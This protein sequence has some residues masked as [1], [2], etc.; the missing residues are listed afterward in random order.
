[1]KDSITHIY[2]CEDCRCQLADIKQKQTFGPFDIKTCDKCT[3]KR[4]GRHHEYSRLY[5]LELSQSSIPCS[6]LDNPGYVYF[7]TPN[8]VSG[9][10]KIG[11]T[12]NPQNRSKDI[13][14]PFLFV[15]PSK[16]HHFLERWM[17][18]KLSGFRTVGEWFNLK[19]ASFMFWLW[20]ESMDCN[21]FEEV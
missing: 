11:R 13:G 10:F 17:H 2:F 5:T 19:D 3:N 12:K 20:I 18:S 1:M 16:D 14:L 9:Q 15:I 4:G 7:A 6:G 21:Y 8:K